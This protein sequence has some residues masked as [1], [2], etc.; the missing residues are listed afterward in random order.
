[1]ELS[2]TDP[3]GMPATFQTNPI[4]VSAGDKLTLSSSDWSGLNTGKLH[5][6]ITNGKNVIDDEHLTN[7]I[8]RP[9]ALTASV[10]VGAPSGGAV[11]LR[12]KANIESLGADRS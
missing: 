4:A 9:D 3:N 6:V 1:A 12:I 11:P 7:Q 5:L 2:Y 8:P 10:S